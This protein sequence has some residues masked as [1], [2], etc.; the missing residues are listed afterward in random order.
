MRKA[1][2]AGPRVGLGVI[3]LCDALVLRTGHST[4]ASRRPCPPRVGLCPLG[5]AWPGAEGYPP[6]P[7]P[8]FPSSC[9]L[10]RG[11]PRLKK[12]LQCFPASCVKAGDGGHVVEGNGSRSWGAVWGSQSAPCSQLPI[13]CHFLIFPTVVASVFSSLLSLSLSL[14]LSSLLRLSLPSSPL[15]VRLALPI[16]PSC[17]PAPP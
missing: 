5:A 4:P 9:R 12:S 13:S 14:S 1:P 2:R 16:S 6:L 7:L 17:P 15:L 8:S 3:S 11:S 10:W